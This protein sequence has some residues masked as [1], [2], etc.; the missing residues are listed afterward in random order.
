[1]EFIGPYL[2]SAILNN[3]LSTNIVAA[4]NVNIKHSYGKP[5]FQR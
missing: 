2:Y 3:Y 1:M 4:M 5:F